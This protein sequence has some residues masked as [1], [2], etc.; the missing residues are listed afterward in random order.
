MPLLN[1]EEVF[2]AFW[3]TALADAQFTENDSACEE[4][5]EPRDVEGEPAADYAPRYRAAVE[6]I[7]DRAE[8]ILATLDLNRFPRHGWSTSISGAFGSDLYLT[9]VGHGAG[10]WDGDWGDVGDSLAELAKTMP[11]GSGSLVE[12]IDGGLFFI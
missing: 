12:H 1:A 9:A 8:S 4:E 3:A 7:C 10:F 6:S 5:R 11:C 2:A